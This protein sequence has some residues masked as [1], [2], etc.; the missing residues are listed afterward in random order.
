[1]ANNLFEQPQPNLF[2]GLSTEPQVGQPAA[3]TE[4]QVDRT[5]RMAAIS[6]GDP[7]NLSDGY[8][9]LTAQY[10]EIIKSA[11]DQQARLEAATKQQA[12]E[13]RGFTK[14]MQTPDT[15]DPT[16]EL[17]RGASTLLQ[18]ALNHNIQ[19]RAEYAMEQR[20]WDRIQQAAAA[21]D[22]TQARVLIDNYTRGNAE[23]V[24]RDIAVKKM[25]IQR[26]IER[27]NIPVEH[28][29]LIGNIVDMV[30]G[31]VGDLTFNSARDRN[32]LVPIDKAQKHWYDMVFSGQ[33]YR[34]QAASLW[35]LRPDEFAKTLR[36]VVIPRVHQNATDFGYTNNSEQLQLLQGLADT[37]RPSSVNAQDAISVA[38][39]LPFTKIGKA[40]D[41]PYMMVRAGARKEAAQVLADTTVA[42][43]T[44]GSEAAAK[45]TGVTTE[46]A[47]DGIVP[48]AVNPA[49]AISRVPVTG[50]TLA[51]VDRS[52]ELGK[53]L[54]EIIQ[55]GRMTESETQVAISKAQEDL[56]E[57]Y[58]RPLKDF[59]VTEET[60][61]D[62]S[63]VS[64]MEFMLGKKKGGGFASESLAKRDATARWGIA[65]PEVVKDESGQYF[66]KTSRV[67]NESGF[68][69]TNLNPGLEKSGIAGRMLLGA[70]QI[71][72]ELIGSMAR[73]SANARNRMLTFFRDTSEETFRQLN[74]KERDRLGQV[75][76]WGENKSVWLD[77]DQLS[78]VYRRLGHEITDKEVAAYQAARDLNDIE[79]GIRNSVM[80]KQD[81]IKGA[82]TI[83]F[84]HP[85]ITGG[86][87]RRTAFI[88]RTAT[89]KPAGRVYDIS[90]DTHYT[91]DNPLTDQ[92]L[93]GKRADGYIMVSMKEPVEMA[94]GTTIKHFLMKP[95]DARIEPLRY[96]QLAYRA[97][98]HRMY[99]D[100]YFVK[101]A[102]WGV[103][104]DTGEKFLKNPGTYISG[105]KAE[106]ALWAKT[107]ETARLAYRGGADAARLDEILAPLGHM[108]GEQ[109]IK[110]MKDG[111]FQSDTSFR[112]MFDR[113]LPEEYV[114]HPQAA[115]FVDLDENG[116]TGWMRTN[117]RMYYSS[118]GQQ[119]LDWKGQKAATID[120]FEMI[121]TS[122]MNVANMSSYSDYKI[123]AVERWV[124]TYRPYLNTGGLP[125][126]ASD[127]TIFQEAKWSTSADK[128]PMQGGDRIRQQMEAQRDIIRRNIGWKTEADNHWMQYTQ[129]LED[130]VMGDD[131]DSVRHMVGK[132]V[133]DWWKD[134]NP[135]SAM[136]GFAFDLKMGLFN[137]AQFPLQIQTIVAATA[138][139]GPI[140]SVGPLMNFLNLRLFLT[141]SGTDHMLNEMIARGAAKTMGMEA[142]EYKA[143]MTS[144]KTSG[145]FE[146]GGSHQLVNSY[147]PNAVA[148]G[149]VDGV[150]KFRKAGRWAFNEGEVWNRSVAW[151]MAWKDVREMYPN[152]NYK[153]N[154]F[155]NR[156]SLKA[157][158]YSMNMMEQSAAAWQHGIASIPTQFFS[159][160]AR[161]LEAFLG[162]Q[163]TSQQKVRLFLAQTFF[164]GTAGVPVLGAISDA[165][166]GHY[167]KG[168]DLNS[169][170]GAFDR[171]M[172][173]QIIYRTT[174]ANVLAGE[175]Y[176][177]GKFLTDTI[178]DVFGMSAYG[179]KSMADLLGGAT[180]S[181]MDDSLKT[182]GNLLKHVVAESGAD[183]MPLVKEDVIRTLQNASTMSYAMKAMLAFNY[184]EMVSNKGT[185]GSADLPKANAAF[186][187]LGIP[188][189]EQDQISAMMQFRK[190]KNKMVDEAAKYI[191]D[192]RTRMVYEPDNRESIANQINAYVRL[193]PEDVRIKALKKAGRFDNKAMIDSLRQQ[194]DK[195]K[196]QADMVKQYGPT[197]Q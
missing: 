152:L 80:W 62:G 14:L 39:V 112:A 185:V 85:L 9:A 95:R 74:A 105:T 147:G 58:G 69:T 56:V 30:V 139:H 83:S 47:I 60:L 157:D 67:L 32:N 194:M 178:S 59:K 81:A 131:P 31:A 118:K 45:L 116:F 191:Q 181:I 5:A 189:G 25:I 163:F 15:I 23:D 158:D 171:G 48:S 12:E 17:R 33:A 77:R 121:N 162:K 106:T 197:D 179:K 164:Y 82:E 34:A 97:G 190:D 16:G 86:I 129:R 64:K 137:F 71:D 136:R 115:E 3:L 102:V 78:E 142:A 92:I 36:D 132:G 40:L 187:L 113:E 18:D 166:K 134:K 184:G 165:V 114:S 54:P 38:T 50:D 196:A 126:N 167:G 130:F 73:R 140:R 90:T 29:G 180:Y 63:S 46:A 122:L 173:D 195:D 24:I 57:E 183:D 143:M 156:V 43:I 144:A 110:A 154:D 176:G 75:M 79:W 155:M 35:S 4:E 89:R 22:D 119:L 42:S 138:L 52:F 10:A 26:E 159:Y 104:K 7:T 107:M 117:G 188:P 98:G 28:Q 8:Q 61:M 111:T 150:D 149:F 186:A 27:A 141:K 76:A 94:D 153:G 13:V 123:S 37:P 44:Q 193:L 21:H 146:F 124:K 174:G 70:R 2:G 120:P 169:P 68:Y 49:P 65:N 99:A 160:N 151:Q 161:M 87:D 101:Q 93:E 55:P 127:M 172:L 41:I 168:S 182:F 135:L 108:D 192:H 66:I 109:F 11:G 91:K 145:F 20:T 51:A 53:R 133:T 128:L 103:Q 100:K 72:D 125:H 88:D 148:G 175:R 84:D 170:I 96:D 1:M 177:G 19:Q 6:N